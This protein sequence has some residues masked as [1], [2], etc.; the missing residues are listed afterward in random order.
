MQTVVS[1]NKCQELWDLLRKTRQE[2]ELSRQDV[3]RYRRE[4][5]KHVGSDDNLYRVEWVR[6]IL[7]LVLSDIFF[8]ELMSTVACA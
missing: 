6:A 4:A 7:V 2:K 5:V 1:D 8:P 3:M